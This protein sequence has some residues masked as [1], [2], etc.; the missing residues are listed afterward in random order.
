[1][2]DVHAGAHAP[3]AYRSRRCS[4][5]I[6]ALAVSALFAVACGKKGPPLPPLVNVPAAP[7]NVTVKRAGDQVTIQFTIPQANQGGVQPAN[8]E[9]VEVYAWTPPTGAPVAAPGGAGAGGGTGTGGATAAP[10]GGGSGSAA[11]PGGGGRGRGG[12]AGGPPAADVTLT[13]D[14]IIKHAK[15]VATVPVRRPP[16]PPPERKEGEPPPP[17]PP[18]PTG[19]G[20][21]QGAV[22]VVI[23]TITPADREPLVL[24][25]KQPKAPKPPKRA[26]REITLTPP[27]L[28]PPL[29]D[30]PA[31]VY[32]VVGVNR[33]G[34]R[35][36]MSPRLRVPL[37]D[38]PPAP[39]DLTATV[40]EGAVDLAWTRPDGLRRP[41][42]TNVA[43]AP[44]VPRPG[45][46]GAGAGTGAPGTVPDTGAAPAGTPEEDVPGVTPTGSTATETSTSPARAIDEDED[47]EDSA[48][49][50][51]ADARRDAAMNAAAQAR[52]VAAEGGAP[53]SVTQ[54]PAESAAP[55]PDSALASA[56]DPSAAGTLKSRVLYPWPASGG[57]FVVYEVQPPSL[58]DVPP[59]PAVQP[60]PRALN[61]SPQPAATFT[62]QRLEY[63]VTRCYAVRTSETVGPLRVESAD[64][65][66]ACVS[67]KDVF[68]PAAPKSLGA[69]SSE[70]VISLIWEGNT[71][72]DLAGYIVLRGV[73]GGPLQ[74]ITRSPIRETTFRDTTVRRGTR[75]TYAV[76]ALD[77]ANPQ[78]RSAES[79]HVEETAR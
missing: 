62:D 26:Q 40:R 55:A 37:W 16:P 75:Y 48:D 11:G 66:P 20:L 56:L 70:G 15:L 78:N 4:L 60:F 18:P 74:P 47:D 46:R 7:R 68:A 12:A 28:G 41:L 31:R 54:A 58:K 45:P 51:D 3:T 50:G 29:P 1:M 32:V 53:Q 69:V 65:Q 8:I 13:A 35:G 64:S 67:P 6:A 59:P 33:H 24:D 61:A 17:P 44:T 21:D 22:A 39:A 30:L 77:N 25:K 14:D 71:E 76:V 19:P 73:N 49:D 23:D 72:G 42:V 9:R 27:D 43:P 38:P 34:R 63:G 5:V 10:P 79:N 2:S 57:G 36:A 52:S